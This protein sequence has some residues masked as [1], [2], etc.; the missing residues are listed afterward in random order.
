MRPQINHHLVHSLPPVPHVQR[1]SVGRGFDVRLRAGG[2]GGGEAGADEAGAEAEALVGGVDGE[3]VE[4]CG[5]VGC[6]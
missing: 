6:G 1:Q 3:D 5:V 4:D 2:V